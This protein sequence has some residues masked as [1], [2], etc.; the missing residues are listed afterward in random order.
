MHDGA[1]DGRLVVL[2]GLEVSAAVGVDE[3][4]EAT[5][6]GVDVRA[7]PP[8]AENVVAGVE[9]DAL[10]GGWD[11]RGGGVGGV[12]GGGRIIVTVVVSG[13]CVFT[14]NAFSV[15]SGRKRGAERTSLASLLVPLKCFTEM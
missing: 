8:A 15:H 5:V 12:G 9:L 14:H 13:G 10:R 11:D 7:T 6:A 2:P 4:S 3:V 1:G